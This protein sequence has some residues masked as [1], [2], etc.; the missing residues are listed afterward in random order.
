M[1]KI[2]FDRFYRYKELT[3]ILKELCKGISGSDS[4]GIDREKP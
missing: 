4:P 3:R 2:R 1:P